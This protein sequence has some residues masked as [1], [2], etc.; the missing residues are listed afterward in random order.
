MK[1]RMAIWATGALVVICWALYV[2]DVL[3]SMSRNRGCVDSCLFDFAR[4]R[5]LTSTPLVPIWSFL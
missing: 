2:S 3:K 5:L 1:H 4:L